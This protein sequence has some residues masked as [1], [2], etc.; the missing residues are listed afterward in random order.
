MPAW[1]AC[2]RNA[3]AVSCP[4]SSRSKGGNMPTRANAAPRPLA[5]VVRLVTALLVT[6]LP[7]S[8]MVPGG[9]LARW[10]CGADCQPETS[11]TGQ[12]DSRVGAVS[13]RLSG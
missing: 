4:R 9:L 8:P 6:R 3:L 1:A 11:I 12:H 7:N 5:P 13:M 10:A 2:A